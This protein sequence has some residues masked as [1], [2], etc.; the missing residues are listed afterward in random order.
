MMPTRLDDDKLLDLLERWEQSRRAVGGA[1]IQALCA[2]CPE[3][4][5]ELERRIRA[6]EQIDSLLSDRES[7]GEPP[8][9]TLP[10]AHDPDRRGLP[11]LLP[12]VVSFGDLRFHA[13]GGLGEVFEGYEE[14]LRRPVA[15]KLLGR[16][17]ANLRESRR[18]FE[19]E[20]EITGRLEHPGIAPVYCRGTAADGRPYYL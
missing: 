8:G 3:L 17:R 14:S 20:A 11:V 15:I 10:G 1:D 4:A 13:R 6:L 5:G 9:L 2:G 16:H 12:A 18:R 7:D 19:T